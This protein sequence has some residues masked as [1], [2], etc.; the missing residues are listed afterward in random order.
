MK[1]AWV[2]Y[3]GILITLCACEELRS[4]DSNSQNSLA[5]ALNATGEQFI[6]ASEAREFTFPQDHGAHPGYKTE[7]WYFTGNVETD[8]ARRFGYQVT[9]FRITLSTGEADQQS[10]WSSNVIYMAHAAVSDIAQQKFFSQERFAREAL[11]LAGVELTPQIKVWLEDWQLQSKE[12]D[13][14]P[15]QLTISDTEFSILLELDAQKNY[16]LQGCLINVHHITIPQ[17]GNLSSNIIPTPEP[18]DK[19]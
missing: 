1:R 16:V 18:H 19:L 11:E 14:F 8:E 3:L 13:M 4:P 2:F 15:L 17:Y 12:H 7:W 5:K 6:R 9:F 10:N